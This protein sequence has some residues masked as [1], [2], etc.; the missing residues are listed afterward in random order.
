M[1]RILNISRHIEI[2]CISDTT[3]AQREKFCLRW[4]DFQE[5]ISS[6]FSGL[7][8]VEEFTDVTLV[9]EDDQSIETHKIVLSASSPVF[10]NMLR[11]TKHSNPVIYMRGMKSKD[12]TSVLDFMYHGQVNIFQEDLQDFLALA[13][14][15]RLKGLNNTAG[16]EAET[17]QGMGPKKRKMNDHRPIVDSVGKDLFQE[18][19]AASVKTEKPET[20]S[21]SLITEEGLQEDPEYQEADYHE[22]SGAL[23]D[24]RYQEIGQELPPEYQGDQ[25]HKVY[26]SNG[27]L[28]ELDLQ[29]ADMMERGEDKVWTCKVC[30]KKATKGGKPD[31]R[32]HIEANHVEGIAHPCNIC[33]N[34]YK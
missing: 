10:M 13:Q 16:G 18:K 17:S 7:W 6:T 23:E 30:G 19:T 26:I 1:I 5:N 15:L 12:L 27:S 14:D 21:G 8:N 32:D 11:K 34:T 31:M 3:M 28:V 20:S 2:T 22:G 33:G 29:I 24:T 25:N 4:N 9:C